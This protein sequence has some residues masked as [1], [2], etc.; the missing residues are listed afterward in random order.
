MMKKDEL[1]RQIEK[2]IRRHRRIEK[3]EAI[4]YEIELSLKSG[5][6]PGYTYDNHR[7]FAAES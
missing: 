2:T 1:Y 3:E 6:N 7:K 5:E 4:A